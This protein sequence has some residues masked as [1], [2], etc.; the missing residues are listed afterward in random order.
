MVKAVIAGCGAIARKRQAPACRAYEKEEIALGFFDQVPENAMALA[1]QYGGQVYDS[2]E[3]VLRDP[4]V[5]AVLVCTPE[6]YHCGTVISCLEAGKHV[7]C[8][9]PM[10]MDAEQA[11]R[12]ALVQKQTGRMLAVAFSQ[13]H[14]GEYRTAKKLIT[15]GAIGKPL[16][17]RTCL[18]NA[19]AEH[20]SSGDPEEFYD[21]C[22]SN[23]GDVMGNVGCHRVDLISWL[24]DRRIRR[25]LAS[26]PTLDKRLSDGALI[27]AA[28]TAMVI[29]QLEGGITGTLFSSW[30]NYGGADADTRVFGTGGSLKVGPEGA[31]LLEKP[32][33][34]RVQVA[35]ERSAEQQAGYDVVWDFLD[36]LTL[37]T[38]VEADAQC[39]LACMETLDAIARSNRSGTWEEAGRPE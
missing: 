15:E 33:G 7:L 1:Q 6:K 3:A 17:F 11:R 16:A 18:S 5:D 23:V 32:D 12:M 39:G 14:Y 8:E 27:P 35:P 20:F 13:R 24:F 38:P 4:S 9:K 36:F 31:V 2:L 10:A 29:M 21:R 28:D 19:G 25:V 37:G 30:C 22:L 26:T 34:T